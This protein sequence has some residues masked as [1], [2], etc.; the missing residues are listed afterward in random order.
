M[1]KIAI[2]LLTF[3][4]FSQLRCA[5]DIIWNSPVILSSTGVNSNDPQIIM[6]VNGDATAAWV[7]NGVIKASFQPV[8]MNWGSSQTLSGSGASSP[9]LGVDSD[10]NVTAIW[11]SSTGVVNSSTLPFNG[12]WSAATAI[13]ASGATFPQLA[14]DP[15]GNV[16]TVWLRSGF[17]ESSTKPVSLT[18]SL[19][20]MISSAISGTSPITISANETE[21]G[22]NAEAPQIALSANGT[23]IAVWHTTVDSQ[24]QILSSTSLIGGV[25]S[26]PKIIT[27]GNFNQ[28]PA[29]AIDDNGNAAVVW[30]RYTTTGVNFTNVYVVY[31]LLPAGET[32][33][34]AAQTLSEAGLGNPAAFTAR[35]GYDPAGN[36][37]ALWSISYNGETFNLESAVQQKNQ[38]FTSVNR[39]IS[40][41]EYAF[42]A[43]AAINSLSNAIVGYMVFDGGDVA[44]QSAETQIA[45]AVINI[46]TSAVNLSIGEG[47]GYPRAAS[48]VT[49]GNII[50][51][52]MVWVTSDGM[53]EIIAASTGSREGIIPP[54]N[55]MVT[56]SSNNFDVFVE[57][58]NTFT[59]N[60]S[61]DPNLDSYGIFRNGQFIGQ[62]GSGITE[63]IDHNVVQNGSITYGV[64]A[65][66]NDNAQSSVTT[67]SFP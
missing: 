48:A 41:N 56:Q 49:G 17:I 25:W 31:S 1:K 59:W 27:M 9:K 62:V 64:S 39:F 26:E 8:G 19:V 6:D 23:A 63:F 58:F 12:T 30:Y 29:V 22:A 54:S 57:F 16:V 37:L 18:W 5:P 67:V 43:H 14:V 33:W 7:E 11:L 50:N 32:T 52:S 40:D 44:I 24:D 60:A 34:S 21:I 28:Y 38:A 45:G 55:P 20:N 51:G 2:L 42:E 10:G 66:T 46:Y 36:L 65:I 15:T 4:V 53:N 35:I 47:N 13:S 3:Y 61:T